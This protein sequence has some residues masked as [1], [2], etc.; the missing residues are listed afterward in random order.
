MKILI[1]IC[2]IYLIN[3]LTPTCDPASTP[4][5]TGV[6]VKPTYIEGCHTYA[7]ST[8]CHECVYGYVADTD[9]KCQYQQQ[10]TKP[11]CK[12]HNLETG[13]CETCEVGLFLE[14]GKCVSKQVLGCLNQDEKGNCINCA[15]QYFLQNGLCKEGI[16]NCATYVTLDASVICDQC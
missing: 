5:P 8:K 11:C 3:P 12:A 13:V 14:S 1:L 7:S 16:L 4:T 9:G 15:K 10:N 2:M 6:C